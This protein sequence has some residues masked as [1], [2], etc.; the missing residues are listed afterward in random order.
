M[1]APNAYA[2]VTALSSVVVVPCPTGLAGQLQANDASSPAAA[3]G[4]LVRVIAGGELWA[5]HVKVGTVLQRSPGAAI[6]AVVAELRAL[7]DKLER[8]HE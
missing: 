7:A 6:G 3:I 1:I 4:S 8:E 2:Y 5:T